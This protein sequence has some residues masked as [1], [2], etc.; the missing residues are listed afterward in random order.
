MY[1]N[2]NNN[3]RYY[4]FEATSVCLF[5]SIY[6]VYSIVV[7]IWL[8]S[9]KFILPDT[10]EGVEYSKEIFRNFLN[11]FG[12]AVFSSIINTSSGICQKF[13]VCNRLY[14]FGWVIQYS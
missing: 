14:I 1:I 2:N 5:G 13:F 6:S 8:M 3:N 12:S 7:E 11:A 10:P 9:T 4:D